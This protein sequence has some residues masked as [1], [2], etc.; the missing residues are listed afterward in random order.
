MHRGKNV[1]F[2]HNELTTFLSTQND[3]SCHNTRFLGQ[4][5]TK[6]TLRRDFAPDPAR[7]AYLVALCG[8]RKRE[9]REKQLKGRND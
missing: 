6:I 5:V 8:G 4:N 2:S 3:P 7:K 1:L 9:E